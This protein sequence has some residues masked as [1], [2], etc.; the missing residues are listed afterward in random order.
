MDIDKELDKFRS[1]VY[2]S[3]VNEKQMQPEIEYSTLNQL[4]AMGKVALLA[5]DVRLQAVDLSA[6]KLWALVWIAQLETPPAITELAD[7]MSSAK[8]NITALVDR[9]EKEELVQR[10]DDPD[11]RRRVL[12]AMTDAGQQRYEAGMAIF[13]QLNQEIRDVFQPE[14]FARLEDYLARLRELLETE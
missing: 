11:D 14:D 4:M 10:I 9:L 13:H 7:C 3:H 8:S 6:P 12:I 5:L 1:Q 2:C